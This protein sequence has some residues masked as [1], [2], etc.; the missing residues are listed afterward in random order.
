MEIQFVIFGLFLFLSIFNAGNMTSLQIQHYSIYYYVGK[1]NFKDYIKANNKSARLPAVIPGIS[2]LIVSFILIFFRPDFM[3]LVEA[4][5]ILVLNLLS[6]F[7]TFKWQRKLQSEMTE[8]GYDENKINIL[9]STNWIRV[10]AFLIQ[11]I[12]AVFIIMS[13]VHLGRR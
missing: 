9:I 7:S 11:G 13:A 8:T 5:V 12:L 3:T 6:L 2:L 10:F 4:I 1:D